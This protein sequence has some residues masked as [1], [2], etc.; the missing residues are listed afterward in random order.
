MLEMCAV[1][2]KMFVQ[3]FVVL[4]IAVGEALPEVT[5]EEDLSTSGREACPVDGVWEQQAQGACFSAGW[6]EGTKSE[7]GEDPLAKWVGGGGNSA[8]EIKTG[9]GK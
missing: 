5:F 2:R 9:L 4:H 1:G 7:G 3:K 8:P 6:R